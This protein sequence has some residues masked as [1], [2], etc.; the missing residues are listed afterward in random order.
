[1]SLPFNQQCIKFNLKNLQD[2]NCDEVTEEQK[3]DVYKFRIDL[4]EEINKCREVF[5][6]IQFFAI[7][8]VMQFLRKLHAIVTSGRDNAEEI[9]EINGSIQEINKG[10]FL[11]CNDTTISFVL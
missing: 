3:F 7:I 6:V 9:P 5:P 8:G 1:M 2:P 4:K 11:Y 10:S